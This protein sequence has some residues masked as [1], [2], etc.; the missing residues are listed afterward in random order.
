MK[1]F[2]DNNANMFMWIG[3]GRDIMAKYVL[4]E[5]DF[6]YDRPVVSEKWSA[7]IISLYMLDI[8]HESS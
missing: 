3:V 5:D 2:I 7:G 6:C 4:S 8:F 1:N